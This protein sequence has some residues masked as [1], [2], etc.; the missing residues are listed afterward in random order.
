MAKR[1]SLVPIERIQNTILLVRGEKVIID[2]DLAKIYG[3]TT[4]RLNEQV[5]RNLDRFPEDFMFRLSKAEK[6]EVVTN[7][8]HL[9]KLRFSPYLPY[10][11]TGHGSVMVANILNSP[12]AVKASIIVVRAFVQLREVLSTH[13]ELAAKLQL[14]ENRFD[15]HDSEIRALFEAIHQLMEQPKP[16]Q[17]RRRKIGFR[18][19]RKRK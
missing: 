16:K 2:S 11:F 4:K 7:C 15:K 17:V 10:V 3:V 9:Q 14:L 12:V 8:D 5:R 13:K 18:I 1:K 19:G 6:E